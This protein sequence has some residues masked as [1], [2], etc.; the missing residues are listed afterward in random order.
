MIYHINSKNK[1]FQTN[2]KYKI[3]LM[4]I[5]LYK[6]QTLLH[7]LL[8]SYIIINHQH[9]M[10]KKVI[11]KVTTD[12]CHKSQKRKK[13]SNSFVGLSSVVRAKMQN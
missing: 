7:F 12:T 4:Q 13:P 8:Q 5:Y 6:K 2:K 10:L 11:T 9:I 3:C 1:H